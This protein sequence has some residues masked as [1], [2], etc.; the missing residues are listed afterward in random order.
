MEHPQVHV[1]QSRGAV[2]SVSI[3]STDLIYDVEPLPLDQ[4]IYHDVQ[5]VS[6]WPDAAREELLAVARRDI[7]VARRNLTGIW[8][9]MTSILR[10]ALV[11]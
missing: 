9:C 6:A 1:P 2:S 10:R 3:A 5:A 11:D 8:T 7:A 4:F